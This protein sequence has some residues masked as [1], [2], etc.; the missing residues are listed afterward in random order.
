MPVVVT[1]APSVRAA[2][3]TL[4]ALPPAW[5]MTCPGRRMAPASSRST[6]R[7]PVDGRVRADAQDH[8]DRA[9][10]TAGSMAS[11][12]SRPATP[13]APPRPMRLRAA[14]AVAQRAASPISAPRTSA[15]RKPASK[16]SPAPTVSR[17]LRLG[18]RD[19]GLDDAG[20]PIGDH[21]AMGGALDGH[22]AWAAAM[23]GLDGSV[24]ALDRE[25]RHRLALVAQQHV[26]IR[27]ARR[28]RSAAT[29]AAGRSGGTA[30]RSRSGC[31]GAWPRRRRP[32]G[33]GGKGRGSAAGRRYGRAPVVA[34]G[35][36]GPAAGR[37][38]PRRSAGGRSSVA[39]SHR[40]AGRRWRWPSRHRPRPGR[41]C[42]GPPRSACGR[43]AARRGRVR[44]SCRPPRPGPAGP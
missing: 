31:P 33:P 40:R 28:R 6:T 19:R 27:R 18:H 10:G 15:S 23:G 32:P 22:D 8:G 36:P 14:V 38:R 9:G 29:V 24:Q 35:R 16:A 41:S 30:G 2:R 42:P 26:G 21:G 11:T 43:A 17:C 25:D 39:W 1:R 12:A 7:Q 44:R 13:S 37:A 20:P 5:T 4:R 34:C 3:A